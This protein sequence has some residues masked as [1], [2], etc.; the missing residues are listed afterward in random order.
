MS[1]LSCTIKHFHQHRQFLSVLIGFILA[2]VFL[3]AG[4]EATFA[5]GSPPVWTPE[6]APTRIVIPK[7]KVDAP[8]KPVGLVKKRGRYEWATVKKGVAWHNLS[9]IP[10]QKGNMVLSGH[11]GSR[12]N[13]V[14]RKLY[15]LKVGDWIQ[16]YAGDSV[17][18]YEVTER[19]ITKERHQSKKKKARNARWIG[20][21]PDERVTLVTCHP[22][23]TNTRRLIIVA[24]PVPLNELR[25]MP[26]RGHSR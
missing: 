13:K 8:I 25:L 17:H 2:T 23:W 4:R 3:L 5:E 14:F 19:V 21:F 15:K 6:G 7:I 24:H 20:V 1:F 9:A 11:N 10:G 26:Y 18:T 22:W 12:G 16:V